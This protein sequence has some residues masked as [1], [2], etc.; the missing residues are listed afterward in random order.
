MEVSGPNQRTMEA[1]LELRSVRG[2]LLAENVANADTPGY[3]ARDLRFDDALASALE[4]E[5]VDGREAS[6]TQIVRQ[7]ASLD[8][9]NVDV[10]QEL[11]KVYENA[12]QYV[13]TLK[14]YS[15]SVARLK[16]ATSST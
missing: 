13:A 4:G 9:N 5:Q 14:L 15:D 3:A 11:A 6:Q 2:E 12:T 8:R 7:N 1:A 10:N 16:A